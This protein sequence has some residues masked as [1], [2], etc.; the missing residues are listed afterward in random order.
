ML[1]KPATTVFWRQVS[2]EFDANAVVYSS[3]SLIVDPTM[4]FGSKTPQARAPRSADTFPS[5]RNQ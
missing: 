5:T 4:D 3:S 1:N 2:V